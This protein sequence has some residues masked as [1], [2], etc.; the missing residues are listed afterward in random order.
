MN[1]TIAFCIKNQQGLVSLTRIL[2]IKPDGSCYISYGS[3]KSNYHFSLHPPDKNHVNGQMHI[4]QKRKMI[5]K[6]EVLGFHDFNVH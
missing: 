1:K 4:K 5:F 6:R 3:R 2:T